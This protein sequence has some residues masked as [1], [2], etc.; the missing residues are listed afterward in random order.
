MF[1]P[2]EIWL[3]VAQYFSLED[4]AASVLVCKSWNEIFISELYKSIDLRPKEKNPKE[5]TQQ[6]YTFVTL[7]TNDNH[8]DNDNDTSHQLPL[9]MALIRKYGHLV[10][11][12]YPCVPCPYLC[13]LAPIINGLLCLHL[14]SPS[15]KKDVVYNSLDW[16]GLSQVLIGNPLI[17][18]ISIRRLNHKGAPKLFHQVAKH[19]LQLEVLC[20][21]FSFFRHED[22]VRVLKKNQ[23]LSKFAFTNGGWFYYFHTPPSE[24]WRESI[25]RLG[26]LAIAP[27]EDDLLALDFDE[28]R[29]LLR[30]IQISRLVIRNVSHRD[31]EGE[32]T[33]ILHLWQDLTDV[34]LMC[35]GFGYLSINALSRHFD[36]LRALNLS[37]SHNFL[38]WMYEIVLA[39]CPRLIELH[40]SL[41]DMDALFEEERHE[42]KEAAVVTVMKR[43]QMKVDNVSVHNWA[44]VGLQTFRVA[45]LVWPKTAERRKR[46]ASHLLAL[47]YLKHLQFEEV[48][49]VRKNSD[50][51]ESDSQLYW[52]EGDFNRWQLEEGID[53][54][55]MIKAWPNLQSF[56]MMTPSFHSVVV[57]GVDN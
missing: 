11:E 21:I 23:S 45:S 32:L 26:G 3:H 31:D 14:E 37:G 56:R 50:T 33:G 48:S 18:S 39:A 35:S 44:C 4:K 55:W 25:P 9:P 41:L 6:G 24:E 7:P 5:T 15:G 12:L 34:H 36:H 47:K 57:Q 17:R 42:G 54:K 30:T 8:S 13:E 40:T 28:L 49:V 16:E 43:L 51:A 52:K 22:M 10:R 46:A 20:V 19:C 53:T 1:L 27:T 29:K 2:S 38:N